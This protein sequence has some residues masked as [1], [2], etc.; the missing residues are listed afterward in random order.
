MKVSLM[1]YIGTRWVFWYLTKLKQTIFWPKWISSDWINYADCTHSE[2]LLE[3][4]PEEINKVIGKLKFVNVLYWDDNVVLTNR[5]KKQYIMKYGLS[6]SSSMIDWWIRFKVIPYKKKPEHWSVLHC[7]NV[8]NDNYILDFMINHNWIK[9][10]YASIFFKQF[11]HIK[12][13][14]RN[15]AY[16]CSEICAKVLL[17]TISPID[18]Y[19]GISPSYLYYIIDNNTHVY[20]YIRIYN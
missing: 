15:D 1:N 16:F 8:E 13:F 5:L 12:W 7:N 18:D 20:K 17:K 10:D 11:L 6:F 2:I 4:S 3:F 9:Y 19:S 14:E